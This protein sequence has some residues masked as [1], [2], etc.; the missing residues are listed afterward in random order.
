MSASS[1]H[2][3]MRCHHVKEALLSRFFQTY[4]YMYEAVFL[5]DFI[6]KKLE[7]EVTDRSL[8]LHTLTSSFTCIKMSEKKKKMLYCH[9]T[10]KAAAYNIKKCR[11]LVF[12][13]ELE[14]HVKCFCPIS[15]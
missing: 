12:V 11:L 10:A 3:K 15:R 4:C 1:A 2:L 7:Y 8:Y 5:N 6:A 13:L 14:E 9:V